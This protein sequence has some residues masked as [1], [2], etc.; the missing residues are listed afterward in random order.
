MRISSG[1]R[2]E[3]DYQLLDRDGKEIDKKSGPGGEPA[4]FQNFV[5]AIR[6]K[7]VKLNSEIGDVQNSSK[8][9]HLA[10]IAYRTTG[11][12]TCDPE[13]DGKLIDNPVGD[14]LWGREYRKGWQPKV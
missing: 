4:H 6:D 9:C 5:D 11:S 3:L 12:V 14:K 10:N 13:A 2:V 7:S 1:V 8:L